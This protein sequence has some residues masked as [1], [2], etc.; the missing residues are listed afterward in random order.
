VR[1]AVR[2][3]SCV[4]L[5]C[6][7]SALWVAPLPAQQ[8]PDAKLRAQREELQRIRQERT[9]LE[10]RMNE[11][12]NNVHDLSEEVSNID[13]QADITA[14]AVKAL[15]SQL[16]SITAEVDTATAD[17]VHAQDEVVVKRAILQR[18]LIDIYKRGP[19]YSFEA[20]LSA[21]T[22]GELVARYKY[23]RLLA[24]RDQALVRRMEDLND[25][26]AKQRELLVRLQSGL[27][28]NRTEKA[29]E[30]QRLRR[31]EEEREVSLKQAR[32]SA[33]QTE[34]RLAQISR[35]EA[36]LTD[37]I[38]SLEAIR[39]KA[40]AA[41]PRNAP[42]APSSSLK[43]SD[44][45]KLTWPVEG[46]I[47]YRFGRVVNPNNTTVKWNGIGISAA[48]GTPVKAIASGQVV[49]AEPFATY[50]LTVIVQHGGGDYSVYSSLSSIDV[51][52]GA[53][54]TKGQVVG[55]VGTNDPELEPH[56]HFEIRPRGHAVDP[57][58]W[59]SDR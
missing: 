51:S 27:S 59:L 43:T 26:I 50:G 35:D 18:R 3:A 52:K 11:L 15:D 23:L 46:T 10:R 39:I 24:L 5:L 45:G 32:R 58:T 7:A 53:A 54:V 21:Q 13:R 48:R 2:R 57:L 28:L 17:L 31:L 49:V 33:K 22:F 47:I 19:L 37:L 55:S 12:K 9:E 4:V 36:K 40:A 34:A 6:L 56:L 16:S 30:E 42:P 8:P 1:L 25:Q 14:R 29:E 44:F 38:A 41:A 20:L